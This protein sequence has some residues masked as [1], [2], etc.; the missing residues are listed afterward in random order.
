MPAYPPSP[1]SASAEIALAEAADANFLFALKSVAKNTQF[2]ILFASFAIFVAFFNAI[3]S[4]MNQIVVPYGYSDDDAG[5]F[6]S[7]M[8]GAGLFGA[9][10][11]GFLIDKTKRYKL[12][13]KTVSPFLAISYIALVFVVQKNNFALICLV[14]VLLGFS[15]F[16]LLPVALELGVECT[17]PNPP[18]TGTSV[19]WMGGQAFAVIFLT[20]GDL[21]RNKSPFKDEPEDTMRTGLICVAAIASL[22]TLM[23]FAF[24]SP[25]YR[26]E[27]ENAK[28]LQH[29][30]N[31]QSTDD[32]A[33]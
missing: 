19:L 23:A 27:A 28:R 24:N 3:S 7:C 20:V 22:T 6:G 18:S 5:I 2:W 17:Y 10:L 30:N 15:S 1:P 25:Y 8:I 13:L 14:C 33:I 4:L 21:I 16:G 26:M 11:S 31:S 9:A 32:N 12:F 29:R